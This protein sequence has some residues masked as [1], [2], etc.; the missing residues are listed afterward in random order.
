M[1]GR[2]AQTAGI[3][4]TAIMWQNL[5]LVDIQDLST[6]TVFLNSGPLFHVG[7]LMITM[8][9]FHIGGTNVFI[10]RSDA[11]AIAEMVHRHRCTIAWRWRVAR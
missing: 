6:D 7:T 9:T 11:K 3:A 4:V 2:A 8:A 5:E 1:P 10:R